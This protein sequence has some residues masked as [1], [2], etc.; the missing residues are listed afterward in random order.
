MTKLMKNSIVL[1]SLL[2]ICAAGCVQEETP[3]PGQY[4]E[5]T[6]AAYRAAIPGMNQLE[7]S[8]PNASQLA[9]LGDPA[10]Y[11]TASW[12]IVL[13]INGSVVGIIVLM[14][15]LVDLEP[16]LYNSETK[17]FVWGPFPNNDGIGYVAAY[18][19]D[20]GEAADFRYHY[21]LLRGVDRDLA[22]LTPV[23]WGGAT[24]D[25]DKGDHGKG[26]TLWD[27]EANYAFESAN[28]PNFESLA[29]DRGRFVTVYGKGVDENNPANELTFVVASFRDFVAKDQPGAEPVDLAYF[30]GRYNATDF[31]VDFLD[32]E[33][34]I[35]VST[36][37]DGVSEQV[38]VRMAFLNQGTGRAEADA[39]GGSLA[40]DQSAN[41]I[42][43][44]DDAINQ[45]YISLEVTGGTGAITF[46]DGELANCGLFTQSLD[47]LKVPSLDSIDPAMRAAL[48]QVAATGAPAE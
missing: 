1:G 29:L 14:R 20:A 10:L 31:Q 11:P 23:I 25:A 34:N 12:E 16:T 42:E 32:Y 48:D 4:D 40:A 24:P 19:K 3:A 33:A 8:G 9:A 26:I 39:V 21:A 7:A 47:E 45:T 36:P 43:C 6:L 38:G 46:E 17:E 18:I 5:Q 30:Y 44:W 28:N 22:N 37:A 41:A 2:S 27:F 35:D 13:G 15:A